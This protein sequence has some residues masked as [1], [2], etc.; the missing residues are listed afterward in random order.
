MAV[1][2]A[3]HHKYYAQVIAFSPDQSTFLS[4]S[5]NTVYICDSE[6]GHCISGPFEIPDSYDACFSPGGKHI[7]FKFRSYAEVW[8]I[9]MGEEQFEIKGFDFAFVHD[10]TIV[11]VNKDGSLDDSGHKGA[12][13]ILIQF[14][15]ASNGALISNRVL[16]AND[17]GLAGLSPDGHFLAII[18]KSEDVIE[19]WNLEDSKDVR[20]FAYPHGNMSFLRFSPTSDTLMVGSERRPWQIYLWRLE[21]QEMVSF[22][23]DF[24]YCLPYVIHSPLANYLFIDQ[25]HT[26]EIWAV[27]ATGSEMIWK[28]KATSP[29][30]VYSICPSHSGDRVLVGYYDGSVRMWNVD[31]E[32]LAIN[33]ADTVD[34]RDGTDVR[35]VITISPS[36]KMA[37]TRS[38]QS[39]SVEFLDTT[40]GEVVVRTDIK[41]ED[42]M[43]IAFSQDEGQVAFVTDSR[44]TICD[45]MHPEKCVSFDPWPG[46]DVQ[47]WKV[48][49]Q[50]CNN[51]V[52][53]GISD[54]H[55]ALLQVWHRQDPAGFECSY[56]LHIKVEGSSYPL[57]APDGLTIIIAPYE[58]SATCYSWNYETAQFDPVHFDDQEHIRWP[59]LP[60]FS[61]DGK[62][63]ACWSDTDSHVRVW[64]ART[65][66][67]VSK[68]FTSEAHGITLSPA[69]IDHPLA[70][71]LIAVRLKHENAIRLFD[72]YT[73][74]LHA[75]ILGQVNA[76]MAFI[77]DGTALAYYYDNFG[78][79]ICKIADLTHGNE[80]MLQ[81][82]TDGW[83]MGKD[84]EPL[85]WV[86]VEHREYLF[87]PP[88][89]AVIEG[90]E[91][92]T[93][94]DLS[95]SRLGKKWAEC[96]DNGW[97][98]ELEQREKEVGELLE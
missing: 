36:G 91:M 97:W 18:K 49:F 98:R 66:Q 32:N 60:K 39:S 58:H 26:V 2:T 31:L 94:L 83:V 6:T 67:L 86:P 3:E 76:Y 52:I 43:E 78:L 74:H 73:G 22:N 34:T 80:P 9:E 23:Y 62:F 33:Q 55:S 7:L 48:A 53:C 14:W 37:V 15:D 5:D 35:R 24:D 29:S 8:D 28:I 72:A 63:F 42:D 12:N 93:V 64:G 70:E 27:S 44:I 75:Q 77:R 17:I 57:L 85:F 50:T 11:S 92:S 54:D 96:I 90:Y 40:S 38:Q 21:T 59:P 79:R 1:F 47:F 68:F 61:P 71:R 10:G 56:S 95:N 84:D 41:Y 69:L 13:G 81:G 65:R 25:D 45:V 19:L 88:F 89:K 82:M 16:E 4:R 46:K 51:L 20:R 30:M 87:A